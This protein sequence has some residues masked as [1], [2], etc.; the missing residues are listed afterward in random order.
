MCGSRAVAPGW[1]P[2]ST[3]RWIWDP[4]FG[5]TWLERCPMG[6]GAVSLRPVGVRPQL[7]G[8]APGP[9]VVRPV[10]SPALVV[11]LGGG[12]HIG[13]SLAR[14]VYWAPLWLG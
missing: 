2:Y 7:L 11:F 3:G 14:P 8:L 10:Y 9:I 6:L 12:V 5:W 13:V 4:R 1:V